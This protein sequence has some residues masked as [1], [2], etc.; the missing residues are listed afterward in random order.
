VARLVIGLTG[1]I[2]TGKSTVAGMLRLLGAE[3][4]D[5]DQLARQAVQPGRPAL[6]QVVQAF[7]QG[8]LLPNGELDRPKLARLAFG[9]QDSLRRL[10]AIIH[11]FV[12]AAIQ[13][14]LDAQPEGSVLVLEVIKLFEGGWDRRCDQVWVTYCVPEAQIARLV[15]ARGLSIEEARLRVEAQP[16]QTE[17]IARADVLLDTSQGLNHTRQQVFAAWEAL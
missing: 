10:E 9:N 14:A 12:R 6:A 16:P 7:G 11:P 13:Q 1:N 3:V 2:A 15:R 5:A 8:V 4:V 17:K